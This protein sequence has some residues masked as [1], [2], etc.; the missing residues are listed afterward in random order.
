V[1]K[2]KEKE[3]RQRKR[4]EGRRQRKRKQLKPKLIKPS[5]PYGAIKDV[6]LKNENFQ[7]DSKDA[8]TYAYKIADGFTA[9]KES[10]ESL[11]RFTK[12]LKTILKYSHIAKKSCR[13]RF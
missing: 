6:L 9:V 10:Q 2:E 7:L 12:L 8:K 3:G 4:K 5:D 13:G 1:E 11:I